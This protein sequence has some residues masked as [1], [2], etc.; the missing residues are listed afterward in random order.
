MILEKVTVMNQHEYVRKCYD[1]YRENGLTPGDPNDGDWQDAHY[2]APQG[3]GD[4]TILLLVDH[5]QV[6]GLL[7]SEEY[8]RC[9]FWM[10]D[11][12]RFLTHGP[13]VERWFELWDVYD[14]W[15]KVNAER[16]HKEK[17]EFGRS[18]HALK[19]LVKA[20][21]EKD[22]FGRSVHQSMA[23]KAAHA[24]KDE[25]GRSVLGVRNAE[26]LNK[27][28]DEFGRSVVGVRNAERLNKEK[29]EFGRSLQG[30]ALAKL[31]NSQKW[32]DPNHPE[33]GERSAPTLVQM[34]KRRGL[35]H[36]KENRVRVG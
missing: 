28:K 2:P 8:G 23:S 29:D 10:G 5:H 6:Q 20:H 18:I 26:R 1:Y 31:M 33:L 9:C 11:A 17:D 16:L 32:V 7:Q 14:K 36:S 24:K 15:S 25:F 35:P 4:T 30:V 19:T 3:D 13:F 27:E 21:D 34:Q 12:K 22:E